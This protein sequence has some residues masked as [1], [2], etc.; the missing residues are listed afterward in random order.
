MRISIVVA[1]VVLAASRVLNVASAQ[2]PGEVSAIDEPAKRR[3]ANEAKLQ[4]LSR[5]QELR[6]L[7]AE[8]ERLRREAGTGQQNILLRVRIV[9]ISRTKLE[10]LGY[11]LE[12][13]GVASVLRDAAAAPTDL[14][15]RGQKREAVLT[16]D[17]GLDFAVLDATGDFEKVLANWKEQG[18]VLKVV[19]EP[20]LMTVSGRA[21]SVH[22]GGR[23]PILVY[24][25]GGGSKLEMQPYGVQLDAV[26]WLLDDGS[27]KLNLRPRISEIDRSQTFTING[28]TVPG[29]RTREFDTGVV[30]KPGQ[31]FA[32]SG[33]S[34]VE[35]RAKR[36]WSIRRDDEQADIDRLI[37]AHVELTDAAD[38]AEDLRHARGRAEESR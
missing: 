7:Q 9:N 23:F 36:A 14:R 15:K 33:L 21:A 12:E 10:Q 30:L 24:P 4:L 22:L 5:L 25:P 35:P 11:N 16:G 20:N 38:A 13:R 37:L 29:L 8:I 1:V 32:A 31:T 28:T 17:L 18:V 3:D 34:V 19:A 6:A 27:V 26:P 2:A